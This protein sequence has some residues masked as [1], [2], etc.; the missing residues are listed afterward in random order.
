ML[1]SLKVSLVVCVLVVIVFSNTATGQ[2][3]KPDSAGLS[4]SSASSI[5]DFASKKTETVAKAK[6]AKPINN[7]S[8]MLDAPYKMAAHYASFMVSRA[9]MTAKVPY[10]AHKARIVQTFYREGSNEPIETFKMDLKIKRK[11]IFSH[12]ITGEGTLNGMP[13]EYRNLFKFSLSQ[14]GTMEVESKVNGKKFIQLELHADRKKSTTM[15]NGQMGGK[16]LEFFTKA[17]KETGYVAKGSMA[18]IPYNVVI[19]DVKDKKGETFAL[20]SSGKIGNYE[21]KGYGEKK[22]RNHYVMEESYGPIVIR[23]KIDLEA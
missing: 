9:L 15:V 18:G 5:L 22:D 4:F 7:V 10:R 19:Q 3:F 21:V 17:S 1:K 8:E 6:P 16:D 20:K 2:L 13:V 23:T 11:S 14:K 12:L